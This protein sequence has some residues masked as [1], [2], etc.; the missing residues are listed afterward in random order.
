MSKETRTI[1]PF[2]G[3]D[4]LESVLDEALLHFGQEACMPN[5]STTVDV[6][7]HE[8][9]LRPV[10]IEWAS[11]EE[12]FSRF[13]QRLFDGSRS[14][15]FEPRDLS[16]VVVASTSYLKIADI[17]LLRPLSD[18]EDLPRIAELTSPIRPEAFSAPFNGFVVDAYVL[19]S[20]SV[21][22]RPL[23]PHVRG[24]WIAQV[25][26]RIETTLGPAL[27]PPTPLTDQVREHHRLP[28]K[29]I[30]YLHFGDHDLLEP[31]R[32]QE[33][34]VFYVD[35]ELL[36]Q[37]NARRTSPASKAVQLQLA[38]DFV[39]AVI[40]RASGHEGLDGVS[41][42]DVRAALLGSVIR[43][44]AGTGTTAADRERL[45]KEIRV[46]PEYVIARA[47]HTIDLA[48]GYGGLLEDGET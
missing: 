30:R 16:L 4:A 25:R 20:N 42:D 8:Y 5:D 36:A 3:I 14:T 10:S 31:Y 21:Q 29:T 12:A 9:L 34:P 37:L 47:E 2:V 38:H 41:Y 45:L 7:P 23:K 13:R 48:G 33:Q 22:P 40:R 11:D 18:I 1:R 44:A 28:A 19:L 43:I 39:S 15:G 35:E 6:A 26:F 27:L 32:E 17:V 46:N 24:T